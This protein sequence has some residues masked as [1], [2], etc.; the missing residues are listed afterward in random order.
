M[1]IIIETAHA[2]ASK[3]MKKLEFL[4][5]TRA[6][7]GVFKLIMAV[8]IVAILIGALIPTAIN[9]IRTGRN[10]SWDAGT[11]ATYDALAILVVIAVLAV[12]VGISYKAFNE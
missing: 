8:F 5:N 10:T 2:R 1:S 12:L 4:K 3:A 11:L 7:A 9:A 6:E